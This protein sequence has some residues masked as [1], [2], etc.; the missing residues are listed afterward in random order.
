MRTHPDE[1]ELLSVMNPKV[2][3]TAI[4]MTAWCS[5]SAQQ[6]ISQAHLDFF[7]K[8][9]RPNLIKYCYECHSV[10][11]NTSRGGLLVDTRVALLQGGDTG[12]ALV[13]GNAEE[14]I[15]WDAINWQHGFEMPPDDPM[16][17]QVIA[18]FKE[19]IDMG[20]PDPREVEVAQFDSGITEEQIAEAR[21]EHWSFQLPQRQNGAS[22]DSIVNANLQATGLNPAARADAFTLLRRINFDLI[23]L[24]PT[25]AEIEAFAAAWGRNPNSAIQEKVDEL[26]ARPQF[27]ER[28]GRHWMDVVRFSETSGS[29]SVNYPN[30]WRYRDY[31]IDSFNEDK[32]YD[33]FVQEQ[34]AGDLLPA[35]DD[36]AWQENLIA[37]GFLAV[38]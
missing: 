16:P 30:A 33:R 32:P 13:P 29:R 17:D 20:A 11:E 36:S 9:I 10:A 26:L 28:W 27:G 12:P 19:W 18:F 37:T 4:L 6:D 34:I 3:S 21:N 1:L 2:L 14:S 24:P 15:F 5:L 31:I 7:E 35:K 23:G 22:V 25:L 38:G 8:N